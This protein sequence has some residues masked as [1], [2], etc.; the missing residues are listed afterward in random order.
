MATGAFALLKGNAYRS[1]W[2]DAYR[3]L[4]AN[5]AHVR[6]ARAQPRKER[7]VSD[8]VLL[9]HMTA[10]L[11]FDQLLDNETVARALSALTTPIFRMLKPGSGEEPTPQHKKGEPAG[12][13]LP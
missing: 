6:S 3:D 12:S 7:V 13:P 10:A 2:R 8:R 4:W 11:P 1:A 9:Q 5:R